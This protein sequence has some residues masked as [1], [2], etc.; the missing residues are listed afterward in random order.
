MQS[1][2]LFGKDAIASRVKQIAS[3]INQDFH[4]QSLVIVGV[5]K[6]SFIFLADLLREIDLDVQTTFIQ[7]KSYEGTASTGNIEII[8]DI[9]AD[10][11]DKEVLLVEDI[12]DTGLTVAAMLKHFTEKKPRSLKICSL[13]HKPDSQLNEIPIDYVGFSISKEF[14]IGYGLDL[15]GKFRQFPNILQLKSEVS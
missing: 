2:V 3:Q 9:D 15:D 1:Q 13:L 7:V 6:G 5:L 8:Q 11:S 12:V 4:G 14:V 10:I